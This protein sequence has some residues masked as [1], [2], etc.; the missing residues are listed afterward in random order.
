M[1]DH[2]RAAFARERQIKG[3][4]RS[5]KVLLIESANPAWLDLA[6]DWFSRQEE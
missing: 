2:I 6:E 4:R 1:T 5:K 3:W